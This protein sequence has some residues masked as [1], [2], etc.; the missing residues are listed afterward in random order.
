MHIIQKGEIS[1]ARV[2]VLVDGENGK[3]WVQVGTLKKSL[4]EFYMP[5][6][7]VY[8][9][10]IEWDE[11]KI[12]TISE[13]IML[14][15]DEYASTAANDLQKYINSLD[16]KEN[17]YTADSYKEFEKALK[18]AQKV[19]DKQAGELDAITNAKAE[20]EFAYANLVKRGDI[21][22]VKDELDT[23]NKLKEK[24]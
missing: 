9:L 18:Q 1:N 6:G 22:S 23:I 21:Q 8:E 13:V 12:P 17:K 14:N 7:N 2:S 20:L 3:K 11:N 19:L 15:D 10:K 5:E 4:N 16:V 24:D